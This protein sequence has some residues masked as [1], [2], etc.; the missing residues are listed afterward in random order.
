MVA[1]YLPRTELLIECSPQQLYATVIATHKAKVLNAPFLS[2]GQT[3]T[4]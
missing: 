2:T 4:F 3:T 1:S